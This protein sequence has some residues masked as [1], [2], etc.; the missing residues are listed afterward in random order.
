MFKFQQSQ[1]FSNH[2]HVDPT[3]QVYGYEYVEVL[4]V[5][6]LHSV[7]PRLHVPHKCLVVE[8]FGETRVTVSQ[9]H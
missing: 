4:E 1:L 7:D 5:V 9:D 3:K 2:I 6:V 8:G